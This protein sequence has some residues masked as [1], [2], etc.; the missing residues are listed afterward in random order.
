[1]IISPRHFARER[2]G[3]AAIEMRFFFDLSDNWRAATDDFL[4]VIEC[5]PSMFFGEEIEIG[6]PINGLQVWGIK[7]PAEGVAGPDKA[8]LPV[9]EINGIRQ[10]IEENR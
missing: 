6:F 5:R 3:D 1:M 9:F 7:E 2:P 4:L 8:R 10:V